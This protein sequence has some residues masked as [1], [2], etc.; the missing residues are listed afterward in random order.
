MRHQQL[1]VFVGAWP[2]RVG[3]RRWD[4]PGG[5]AR[6]LVV[7]EPG[8]GL[9]WASYQAMAQDIVRHGF[10]VVIPTR[11]TYAATSALGPELVP[12]VAEVKAAF[13]RQLHTASTD[14]ERRFVLISHSIGGAIDA[15]TSARAPD[16]VDS[17]VQINP[18]G[19]PQSWRRHQ[20]ALV[21]ALAH[22]GLAQL[23]L[24][25]GAAL[26][27]SYLDAYRNVGTAPISYA[28]MLLA[29]IPLDNRASIAAA[30]GVPATIIV[31]ERDHMVRPTFDAYCDLIGAQRRVVLPAQNHLLGAHYP[32]SLAAVVRVALTEADHRQADRRRAAGVDAR[33]SATSEPMS[34]RPRV[35]PPRATGTPT[36][37]NRGAPVARRDAGGRADRPAAPGRN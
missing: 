8:L 35:A 37:P 6:P 16:L 25:G 22:V 28:Q 7:L 2:I 1:T 21:P 27:R 30:R 34:R 5:A 26:L 24:R 15:A 11:L 4:A 20:Y 9:Q 32:E 29:A 3:Y 36:A 12:R 19:Y 14:G 13:L 31:G 18:W 23:S 17:L 10:S 33:P